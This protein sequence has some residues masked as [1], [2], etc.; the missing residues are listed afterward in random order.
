MLD[1]F[2]VEPYAEIEKV[3]VNKKGEE[4]TTYEDRPNDL[5]TYAGFARKI[6][7]SRD[8]LHEWANAK[9]DDGSLK[10]PEFSNAYTRVKDMQDDHLVQNALRGHFNPQF[11]MFFA[12]NC[13]G[14]RY[15]DK[16]ETNVTLSKHPA[17]ELAEGLIHAVTSPVNAPQGRTSKDR[18][19]PREE[20]DARPTSPLADRGPGIQHAHGQG[21]PER[22]AH[23]GDLPLLALPH[24]AERIQIAESAGTQRRRPEAK[25]RAAPDVGPVQRRHVEL[26]GRVHQALRLQTGVRG[27]AARNIQPEGGR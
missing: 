4:T 26:R 16:T 7:A 19:G 3:F 18:C 14:D 20:V 11:S 23:G 5:P 12:K 1:Y 17:E 9:N 2:D 15:K 10:H 22:A 25:Q 6:G 21:V 27:R 8:T 24:D 13:L